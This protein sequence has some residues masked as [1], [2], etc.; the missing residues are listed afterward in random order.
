VKD[1]IEILSIVFFILYGIANLI[2]FIFGLLH[3]NDGRRNF[4]YVFCLKEPARGMVLV[5][6]YKLGCYL[7]SVEGAPYYYA[8]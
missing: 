6:A 1:V 8:E 4:D 2:L 3:A 7:G 5:P